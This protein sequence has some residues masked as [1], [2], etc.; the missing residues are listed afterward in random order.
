[1]SRESESSACKI[2]G[3]DEYGI[4]EFMQKKLV[5]QGK[6]QGK[7]VQVVKQGIEER[8]KPLHSGFI[9]VQFMQ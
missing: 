7:N 8:G 9:K 3:K 6:N 2:Y 4:E 5:S 1:M